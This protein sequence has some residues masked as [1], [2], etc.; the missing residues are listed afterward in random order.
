MDFSYAW[1]HMAPLCTLQYLSDIGNFTDNSLVP[2]C[3]CTHSQLGM[4][5]VLEYYCIRVVNYSTN[6]TSRLLVNFYF[7]LQI[8]ISGCSSLQSIDNFTPIGTTCTPAERKTS[9]P[10]SE[11]L[12]YWCFVLRT[13][14]P[15]TIL[16][17]THQSTTPFF[18]I[19]SL[20]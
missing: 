11:L 13:M 3:P 14:L 12:K 5:R 4:P 9:K 2:A 6:F 16:S 7:R 18:V 15:V 20:Y 8:S 10:A 17:L 1:H 19:G